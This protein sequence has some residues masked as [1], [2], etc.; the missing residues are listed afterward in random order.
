MQK[1]E[2]HFMSF[3][4]SCTFFVKAGLPY[5]CFVDH[6]LVVSMLVERSDVVSRC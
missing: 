5:R 3:I 4:V 2:G 6:I 1:V